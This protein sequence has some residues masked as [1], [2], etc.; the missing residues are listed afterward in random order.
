MQRYTVIQRTATDRR[1]HSETFEAAH[2]PF[3]NPEAWVLPASQAN[4]IRLI[5]ESHARGRD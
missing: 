2:A 5:G 3:G 4:T 1:V